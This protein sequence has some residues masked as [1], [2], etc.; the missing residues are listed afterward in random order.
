M[1]LDYDA[2]NQAQNLLKDLRLLRA[3]GIITEEEGV[4]AEAK[5]KAELRV[6]YGFVPPEP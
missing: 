6:L 5:V 3:D 4:A 2:I 1:V